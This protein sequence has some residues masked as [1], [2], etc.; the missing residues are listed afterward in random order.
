LPATGLPAPLAVPWPSDIYRVDADGT[1]ADGLLDWSLAGIT[2]ADPSG[3]V[4]GYGGLDGFG[5]NSGALFS[6][7][8]LAA[9]D[10]IDLATLPGDPAA[11]ADPSANVALLDVDPSSPSVARVPCTAGWD[12]YTSTLVVAPEDPL[13]PGHL[14]AAVVTSGVHTTTGAALGSTDAFRAIRDGSRTSAAAMMYGNAIDQAVATGI[15]KDHIVA[16]TVFT[17]QTHGKLRVIRDAL[18]AGTYGAAPS[19]LTTSLTAPY[20]YVRFG[21]TT[22]PGWTATLAEWLGTPRKDTGGNDLTGF[23]GPLETATPAP[24]YDAIGVVMTAAF[25][26]PEFRRPF[27]STGALDDGT[28]EYDAAGNAVA[29]K[30]TQQIPVT[31]VLPKGAAPVGGFPVVII[32]HG[33]GSSRYV[34][35]ALTN[36]LARAGIASVGIDAPLHGLRAADATDTTSQ[37][38]GTYRGPDG[39]P[40]GG[41]PFAI[42][43]MNGNTR[44]ALAARD[45]HWQ[46]AL[47]LVQLRRLVGNCDLSMV[48]DEYSGTTPTFDTTHVGL[49]GWSMGGQISTLFSSIEPR[50]S[51]NPVVLDA[52]GT[53][54]VKSLVTSPVY[55]SQTTLLAAQAEVSDHL[56]D[57]GVDAAAVHLLQGMF[58]AEDPGA[59]AADVDHDL[60]LFRAYDDESIPTRWT[61]VLARALGATQLTPT[62]RAVTGLT[63][64]GSTLHAGANGRVVGYFETEPGNHDFLVSR[65]GK[66]SYAPPYP[67]ATDPLFVDIAKPISIRQPVIGGQLAIIHFMQTTWAGAPEIDVANPAYLGLLPVA[68]TD[69]DGYCDADETTAGSDP[70]DASSHPSSGPANCVRDVGFAAP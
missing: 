8:G 25:V 56:F 21:S 36:E 54:T 65:W 30:T 69:D 1:I 9:L 42:V 34:M 43:V 38:N 4:A 58:D 32:Q 53:A 24:A 62:H 12:A 41:N 28:I 15:A 3:L 70:L 6:I 59:F 33:L 13:A 10:G 16:L 67:R 37:G 48:A 52:P 5:R 39:F 61:D 35:L 45:N 57:A 50:S 2:N 22:H 18:A 55:N 68:D 63:Q 44:N 31:I 23:A 49:F 29:Y 20:S 7:Q 40:D 26:S 19:V 60:W 46:A 27:A 47:D 11:G 17:T 64:G 51:V 66:L 14:Y